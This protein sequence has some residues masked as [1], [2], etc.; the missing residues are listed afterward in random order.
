MS[1]WPRRSDALGLPLS[2]AAGP[3]FSG[4][5]AI[6][7][8][9]R[10][11][12]SIRCDCAGTAS[13]PPA[14]AIDNASGKNGILTCTI[15]A[16]IGGPKLPL[17]ELYKA[18]DESLYQAKREGRNRVRGLGEAAVLLSLAAPQILRTDPGFQL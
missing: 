5:W 10:S 13:S 11:S 2:V 4:G 12:D 3:T 18:A 16:V 9:A 8:L 7:C 17:Y 14:W 1:S 6:R 15:G